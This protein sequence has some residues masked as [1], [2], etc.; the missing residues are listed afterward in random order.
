MVVAHSLFQ[1]NE[2]NAVVLMLNP[3]QASVVLQQG[4]R[5]GVLNPVAGVCC[6][7]RNIRA[8]NQSYKRVIEGAC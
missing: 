4:E 6:A 1:G 8:S 3:C 7:V 5:V 2:S